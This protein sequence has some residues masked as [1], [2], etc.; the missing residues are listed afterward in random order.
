MILQLVFFFLFSFFF[1]LLVFPEVLDESLDFILA[2][3]IR[4]L[5]RL[6]SHPYFSRLGPYSLGDKQWAVTQGMQLLPRE[7]GR[8]L[9]GCDLGKVE[10]RSPCS[11]G[12]G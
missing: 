7:H 9:Q 5:L 11:L 6:C 2:K 10:V 3:Y 1:F 8:C 4:K 12:L